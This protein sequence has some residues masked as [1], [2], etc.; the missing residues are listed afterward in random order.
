MIVLLHDAGAEDAA[1][2]I[3]RDLET[4]FEG[5]RPIEIVSAESGADL[6]VEA[7]DDLL[8]VLFTRREFPAAGKALIAAFLAA[9]DHR[10]WVL[11]IAVDPD[12]P[13]P[14]EPISGLKA[15]PFDPRARGPRGRVANRVG[16]ILGLRLRRAEYEIFIS[17]RA[18]DGTEIAHQLHALLAGHGFKTF[19]DEA[20]EVDGEGRIQGG[21]PVQGVIEEHVLR[22]DMV[23]LIDTPQA[24]KSDWIRVEIDAANAAMVPVLP[25]C[26]RRG[27]KRGPR[28]RAL[29][30]L[31]RWVPLTLP[32]GGSGNPLSDEDLELCLDSIEAFLSQ[33]YRRKLK[34]PHEI[35]RELRTRDFDW[36]ALDGRQQVYRSAKELSRRN[37]LELISHC[38]I[39]DEIYPPAFERY[40]DFLA[41]GTHGLASNFRLFVYGGEL[42]PDA[43][44]R[45][46]C[47]DKREEANVFVVHHGELRDLLNELSGGISP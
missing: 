11:P 9:A 33:I 1:A 47:G 22:A 26:F 21:E 18:A 36:Q 8:L 38:S 23:L 17:Y 16:A 10:P 43:E 15:I 44:V 35:S 19:L 14:P 4:A 42:I 25:I 12:R 13:S 41:A 45:A 28:F 30:D 3:R 6:R 7:W 31:E 5:L 34:L 20:R 2:E 46:R 40:V 37:R 24:P 27:D 29:R 32:P 39:L